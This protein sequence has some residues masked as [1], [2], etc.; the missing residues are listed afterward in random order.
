MR[1]LLQQ[2]KIPTTTIDEYGAESEKGINS[3]L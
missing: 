1:I 2:E 3:L